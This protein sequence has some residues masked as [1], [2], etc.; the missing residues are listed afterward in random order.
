M[1]DL[2]ELYKQIQSLFDGLENSQEQRVWKV[3]NRIN[4]HFI[5]DDLLNPQD[6]RELVTSPEFNY[7]DGQLSGM[8]AARIAVN[9]LVKEL[10]ARRPEIAAAPTKVIQVPVYKAEPWGWNVRDTAATEVW[11]QIEEKARSAGSDGAVVFDLDGTL[12]D[13][14]HRTL[15]IL[16]EWLE[17]SS[18]NFP[19]DIVAHVSKIDFEHVGYSLAHAFENV[20]LDLRDKQI[21][22]IFTSAEKLWKKRFFDG[23]TLTRFDKPVEGASQF[24][25]RCRE[26]GLKIVYLT[27]RHDRIMR[28]GT[29][30]QLRKFGFP[31]EGVEYYLKKDSAIED[32]IFKE[33][34]FEDIAS[35]HHV[36]A[37]FENEYVNIA[38][39]VLTKPDACHV[40]LDTQH[41]GRPVPPLKHLVYRIRSFQME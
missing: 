36:V 35:R 40:I 24:A 27:G 8:R 28:A 20:G 30:E 14:G 34:A 16:R 31:H 2:N 17:T 26:L 3:A 7:E 11:Q 32:V 22:E 9:S 15:G 12:F 21:V 29:I 33:S 1:T 19:K 10:M 38:S 23:R 13:V 18:S 39:M 25:S 37:N 41:S 5:L 6:H 4:P